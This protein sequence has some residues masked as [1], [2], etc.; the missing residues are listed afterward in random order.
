VRPGRGSSNRFDRAERLAR[1]VV[2]AGAQLAARLDARPGVPVRD[3]RSPG[4]AVLVGARRLGRA[5]RHD[6]H[7]RLALRLEARL[8]ADAQLLRE[9][10]QSRPR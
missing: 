6:A 8:A 5:R 3:E 1:E 2:E 4:D 7:A 9:V 10:E